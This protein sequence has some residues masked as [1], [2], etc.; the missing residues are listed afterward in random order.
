MTLDINEDFELVTSRVIAVAAVGGSAVY[1]VE[2]E[3]Q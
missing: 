2:T 1:V 3:A